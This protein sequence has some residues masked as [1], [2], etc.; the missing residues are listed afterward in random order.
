M[1]HERRVNRVQ[2]DKVDARVAAVA[3][4][5]WGIVD[6]S[7]LR[8]CGLSG[9][10]ISWRVET[11][12]IFPL[13]RGVY[14]VGHPNVPLAGRF[15]AAVKACGAGAVLSH[16]AAAV[17]WA[18]LPWFE[19]FPE[20]T[21]PRP[22]SHPGIRTHRSDHVERVVHN[23]IP[24]TPPARTLVDL[25]SMLP[26]ERLRRAVNEALNQRL[27]TPGQLVTTDHRGAKT[28][29]R[30]LATAAPTRNDFEDVVLA[31]LDGLPR[32]L[33]NVPLTVAGR[34]Y[35]PDYRWPEHHLILEA[36]GGATHGHLLARADDAER[37]ALL[38]AHGERVVRV[39]W[40]QATQRPRETRERIV[41]ALRACSPAP[42]RRPRS[43][44]GDP[45]PDR[46]RAQRVLARTCALASLSPM[47]AYTANSP[48]EGSSPRP[49]GCKP[50][51]SRP[52]DWSSTNSA[53]PN[54]P[55]TPRRA[56]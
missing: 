36:D 5:Q 50:S 4:R 45:R 19:R 28:L 13:H 31:L 12:R 53:G 47:S 44:R 20:I 25:A 17:W 23:G 21:T 52:E 3:A 33:V 43:V 15:L 51:A 18:L 48:P 7:E 35:V 1:P 37:Q 11:G 40:T 22:R 26:Y 42:A 46:V 10:A 27:V 34:T 29:R 14:A 30:I 9:E 32:P 39:S 56:T 8:A 54:G 41:R 24:V 55:D 38:E 49:G 6:V 2:H 16:Y